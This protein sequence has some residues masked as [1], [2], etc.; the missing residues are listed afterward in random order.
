MSGKHSV[1]AAPGGGPLPF[2]GTAP[3]QR[4]EGATGGKS[5]SVSRVVSSCSKWAWRRAGFA[6][7]RAFAASCRSGTLESLAVRGAVWQSQRRAAN[8][9]SGRQVSSRCV[10]GP[11]PRLAM[12][13]FFTKIVAVCAFPPNRAAFI[14][15]WTWPDD[16][17]FPPIRRRFPALLPQG[18]S[19]CDTLPYNSPSGY[20]WPQYEG[21][22]S[23]AC[24]A[25]PDGSFGRKWWLR[26]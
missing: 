23:A 15:P 18:G 11:L 26:A 25:R 17:P 3:P 7:P 13:L 16:D 8:S 21:V 10:V 6:C 14:V 2:G 9:T 1:D 20:P 12:V 24:S 22:A 5:R 4:P 19:P